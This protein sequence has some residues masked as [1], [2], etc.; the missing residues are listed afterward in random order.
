MEA[1]NLTISVPPPHEGPVCDKNCP[2]CISTMTGFTQPDA[3]TFYRNIDKAKTLAKA[4]NVSNVLLTGKG[5]PL[6]NFET[7]C[8]ILGRFIEFPLEIQTNGLWLSKHR[9]HVGVLK[10]AGL[11]IIAISIDHLNQ[12]DDM[13]DLIKTIHKLNM[14]CRIC[15]NLT[16]RIP[17]ELGFR[18]V[19]DTIK[20]L[21]IHQLLIRNVMTPQTVNYDTERAV[22][23]VKWIA[24]HV[25]PKVYRKLYID[26]E[27]MISQEGSLIR[28]LP[29]G[30]E[31]WHLQGIDVCFSDYCLQESNNTKDIRSLIFL[32]D[33]HMY[34]SWDKVPA[35]RLF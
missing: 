16:D 5:E 33:G 11:D 23:A 14:T 1:Q 7:T 3:S 27:D 9:D 2:Y 12:L 15:L 30:A 24:E 26:F 18:S 28:E 6:L 20:T 32:E 21:D 31:V 19:F 29:H 17:V 13:K 4:A 25:D 35:S 10:G 8:Y 34:T 22:K